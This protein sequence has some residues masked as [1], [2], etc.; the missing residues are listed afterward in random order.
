M[1]RQRIIIGSAAGIAALYLIVTLY[2]A[3]HFEPHTRVNGIDV[4]GMTQKAAEE[5]LTEYADTY[6]LTVVG[7]DNSTA[8]VDG[9]SI[10]FRVVDASNA[11]ECLSRQFPLAWISGIFKEKSYQIDLTADFDEAA[12]TSWMDRLPMLSEDSMTAPADAYLTT[13]ADGRCTIVPE[14]TGTTVETEE[15]RDLIRQTVRNAHYEA[16]LH[17]AMI[18]PKVYADDENLETRCS[19]WNSFTDAAG[20]TYRIAGKEEVFTGPVISSLL[21]DDG[22]HVTLSREKIADMM[23]AWRD[24]YD[25]YKMS[26]PFTTNYGNVVNIQP[27]GDYGFELNEDG[28]CDDIIE[29]ISSGDSGSYE[30]LY[31]HRPLFDDNYGLGGTYVEVNIDDQ[32]LWVYKNGKVVVDT[33]VVTGKP[34]YGSITYHGCYAIKSKQREVVLGTLDLQGYESPVSYWVPFNEGEGLHDAPWREY[35]GGRIWLTNGSHGC[36][37]IPSWCMDDV[38][39]NVQEGEAV[40][41]YGR[42]YDPGVYEQGYNE[43]NEDYYYDVYYNYDND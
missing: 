28:T 15:A 19:E 1:L 21:T 10:G 39:N 16:D 23:S 20:L 2:Y 24:K 27:Y 36:V 43:V 22:E 17:S 4:S 40:V 3:F 42:N 18:T 37:N 12:L 31:Y 41:V 8:S 30:V 9:S 26:F 5:K 32:H 33:D 25:T 11:G 7:P 13:D 14:V 29:K 6:S 34:I 35:F 38:Y